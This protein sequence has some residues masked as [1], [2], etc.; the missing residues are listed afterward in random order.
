MLKSDALSRYFDDLRAALS[1]LSRL[2][3]PQGPHRG[4]AAAWAYPLAG[5]IIGGI[6]GLIGLIA[7]WCGL[8]L[9]L[10]SL[11][12]LAGMIIVT[13]AMHEDGLADTADGLW[14]GWTRARRLEIMK[15]S[16][17][18][19][20][21]TIALILSLSARWAALWLLFQLDSGWAMAAIITSA[22]VSR[23]VM[24]AVMSA[25]PHARG[26]GLSHATGRPDM[27][28][29]AVAGGIAA[30]IALALV[31]WSFFGV[32]FWAALTGIAV[33]G[34]A[35]QKIGGQT[36]DILGAAQQITEIA[37]LLSLIA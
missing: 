1:L 2:P 9:A 12:A 26:A 14:G 36:G 28:T 16:H 10:A 22:A 11:A 5:A 23:A 32:L 7:I 17:V 8:P 25:L 34:I 24:V 15:D 30:L 3:L 31:G 13:G 33:A 27:R 35:K 37:V 21:G 29:C 20:F 18:G 19:A 6:A 4:A